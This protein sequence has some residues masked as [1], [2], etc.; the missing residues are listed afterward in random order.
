VTGPGPRAALG[1]KIA[2]QRRRRGLSQAELAAMTG[3]SVAW[4]SQVER[5]VRGIDRMSVLELVAR[6]LEVPLAELA[7][8][9]PVVAALTEEPAGAGGLR[10]VL[11]GVH[12]LEPLVSPGEPPDLDS[13]QAQ[14][15]LAWKLT[16]TSRYTELTDLMAVLVPGLE[17]AA[18]QV[19]DGQE[20]AVQEIMAT[21]YQACSAALAKLGDAEAAWIAAD[22]A[23]AAAGRTGRPELVA[24]GAYRQVL[25]FLAARSLDQADETARTAADAIALVGR[26]G[27][28]AALS[29][30]GGLTLHR[31]IIAARR[32]DAGAAYDLLSRAQALADRVGPGRN[33]HHTEFGPV[34][35]GVQEVAIAIEVGDAGRAL[36]TAGRLDV[37]GLSPERRSR[38]LLDVARAHAQLRQAAGATAALL[39]AEEIAPEQ[40]RSHGLAR[41]LAADLLT[42]A[43]PAPE[44]LAGFAARLGQ[45]SPDPPAA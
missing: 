1:R 5:G 31:A 13:L 20:A 14:A 16:H 19:P 38:L 23:I 17:A 8:D 21:A 34:N 18:H 15:S 30:Q 40:I 29:L 36:R 44:G 33:D 11:S 9:T 26:G 25:V 28:L 2:A 3:R 35:V 37:A 43:S 27:D 22:R 39:A 24:A 7:A 32:G 6:A 12:S 42:M 41:Q 45:A 10:L 4:V